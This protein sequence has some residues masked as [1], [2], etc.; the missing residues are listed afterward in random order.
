M[1]ITA[2]CVLFLIKMGLLG[3]GLTWDGIAGTGTRGL[4]N[5]DACLEAWD[6][7]THGDR[8]AWGR[9]IR[10]VYRGRWE[11][12]SGTRGCGDATTEKQI[13][14]ETRRSF[15]RLVVNTVT[16]LTYLVSCCS[17]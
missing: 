2:V 16:F 11:V 1:F 14:W 12:M 4:G 8:D 15:H 7:G 6:S 9:E 10:D 3:C 17:L 13:L 5:G